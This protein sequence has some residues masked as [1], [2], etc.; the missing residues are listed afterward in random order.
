MENRDAGKE[1]DCVISKR[2]YLACRIAES[3]R[4]RP[5]PVTS[6]LCGHC[7]QRLSRKVFKKH[8]HLY[9]RA[10]LSWATTDVCCDSVSVDDCDVQSTGLW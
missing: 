7:N 1:S 8:E 2:S 5:T 6:F 4:K 9:R 3:S 10:D